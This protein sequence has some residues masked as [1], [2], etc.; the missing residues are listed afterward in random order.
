M[1]ALTGAGLMPALRR[2]GTAAFRVVGT[3]TAEPWPLLH[4][5]V[6]RAACWGGGFA[7]GENFYAD[8]VAALLQS[9]LRMRYSQLPAGVQ[10]VF[11]A[12]NARGQGVQTTDLVTPW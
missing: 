6:V 2:L 9:A 1:A 7:H 10:L 4:A 3:W 11:G 12:E 8:S 5:L